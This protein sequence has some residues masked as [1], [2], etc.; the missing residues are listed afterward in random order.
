[1]DYYFFVN[2]FTIK[3]AVMSIFTCLSYAGFAGN[4]THLRDE[5][6]ISLTSITDWR[7]HELLADLA[8]C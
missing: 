4:S 6:R 8:C 7:G 5:V 3:F 2:L 1:M